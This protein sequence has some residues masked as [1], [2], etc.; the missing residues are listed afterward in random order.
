MTTVAHIPMNDADEPTLDDHDRL[1]AALT[2]TDH[3]DAE[4]VRTTTT[5]ATVA[6]APAPP[7]PHE[8]LRC[9]FKWFS[10]PGNPNPRTCANQSCRSAYWDQPPKQARARRPANTDW[11][12]VKRR[13]IADNEDRRRKAL[14][15]KATELG[16]EVRRPAATATATATNAPP[17]TTVTIRPRIPPV[18][19]RRT[20]PPPPGMDD[21]GAGGKP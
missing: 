18:E 20:V 12:E 1:W 2:A 7:L 3:A 21:L 5:T 6:A 9:G 15:R 4:P 10:R 17:D 13:R 19:F 8:C 14:I 16:M 11:E